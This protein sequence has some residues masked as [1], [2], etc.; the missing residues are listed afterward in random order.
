VAIFEPAPS[1]TLTDLANLNCE[2]DLQIACTIQTLED[3]FLVSFPRP[4]TP[5]R[6]SNNLSIDGKADFEDS[7]MP[8]FN[9]IGSIRTMDPC[10]LFWTTVR[11]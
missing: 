10:K 9:N 6:H 11:I 8:F 1:I 5:D 4:T 2:I 7:F 3:A